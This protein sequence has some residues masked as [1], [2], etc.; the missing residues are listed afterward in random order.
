MKKKDIV[1]IIEDARHQLDE[2]ELGM[3]DPDFPYK[4][5]QIR[6]TLNRAINAM[7]ELD[8]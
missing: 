6:N 3:R 4:L 8:G 5:I 1:E 7:A 2:A